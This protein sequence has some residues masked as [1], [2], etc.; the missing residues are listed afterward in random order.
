[1]HSHRRK[2]MIIVC[3][4][5]S[6]SCSNGWTQ[7]LKFPIVSKRRQNKT[8]QR[9][10]QWFKFVQRCHRKSCDLLHTT[11]L[12]MRHPTGEQ[13]L[14]QLVVVYQNFDTDKKRSRLPTVTTK[15]ERRLKHSLCIKSG[16]ENHCVVIPLF[17]VVFLFNPFQQQEDEAWMEKNISGVLLVVRLF[18]AT[19]SRRK[20]SAAPPSGFCT[21]FL[22]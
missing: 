20:S 1:M 9:K 21:N 3:C 6:N 11:S 16:L 5:C 18:S 19:R 10:N 15:C 7:M 17:L 12:R 8:I 2:M 13:L 22:L 4:C 14:L